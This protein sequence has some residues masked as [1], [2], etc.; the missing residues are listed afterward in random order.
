MRIIIILVSITTITLWVAGFSA[1]GNTTLLLWS[2]PAGLGAG[3][4]I[5]WLWKEL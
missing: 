1:Q 5:T 2:W 3:T 4:A